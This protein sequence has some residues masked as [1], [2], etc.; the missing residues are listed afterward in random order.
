MLS[1]RYLQVVRVGGVDVGILLSKADHDKRGSDGAATH[2]VVSV[3]GESNDEEVISEKSLGRV[4]SSHDSDDSIKSATLD[5][6]AKQPPAKKTTT[7]KNKVATSNQASRRMNTRARS[8]NGDESQPALIDGLDTVERKAPSP[9][10]K[11]K[12]GDETVVEVEM[13]TGTLFMY[14]GKHPR[15][16]F[17]RTV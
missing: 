7:A 14:R 16:E 1:S 11:K 9:K 2:W 10:P 4:L 6:N 17:V 12:Q 8:K 5:K 13:L 3:E 15:V